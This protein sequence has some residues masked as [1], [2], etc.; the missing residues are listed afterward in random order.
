MEAKGPELSQG[1]VGEDPC[2]NGAGKWATVFMRQ[3]QHLNCSLDFLGLVSRVFCVAPPSRLYERNRRPQNF[4][5]SAAFKNKVQIVRISIQIGPFDFFPSLAARGP[6]LS[7]YSAWSAANFRS[8]GSTAPSR[9]L[10]MICPKVCASDLAMF[11]L[12]STGVLL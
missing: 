8:A 3:S 1:S 6:F 4:V 2:E 11:S 12:Q 9:R 7:K 5:R 10:P